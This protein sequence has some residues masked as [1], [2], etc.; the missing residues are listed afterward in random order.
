MTGIS[1]AKENIMNIQKI[2]KSADHSIKKSES[3]LENMKTSS[4]SACV[5]YFTPTALD[6]YGEVMENRQKLDLIQI[7]LS[8]VIKLLNNINDNNDIQIKEQSHGHPAP[9]SHSTYIDADARSDAVSQSTDTTEI[10]LSCKSSNTTAANSAVSDHPD[11]N[12]CINPESSHDSLISDLDST[13]DSTDPFTV[14][15]SRKQNKNSKTS[16]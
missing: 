14:V 1:T 16:Q 8:Q 5:P 9:D 3:W 12:K 2:A 4:A 6:I 13:D 10:F 15:Q 7:Q 11:Q